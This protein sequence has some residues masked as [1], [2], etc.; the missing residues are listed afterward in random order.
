MSSEIKVGDRVRL[1]KGEKIMV[2]G[3]F[4]G[5]RDIRYRIDGKWYSS[6]WNIEKI[7][8]GESLDEKK[9]EEKVEGK[10]R[11]TMEE[12]FLSVLI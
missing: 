4:E 6:G 2:E 9:I 5:E 10:N 8:E 12:D 11:T 7:S 1:I 3:I